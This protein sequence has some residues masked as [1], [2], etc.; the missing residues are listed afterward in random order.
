MNKI[1]FFIL[2][3]ISLVIVFEISGC[4]STI[5]TKSDQ[6]KSET[7]SLESEAD[8]WV[9]SRDLPGKTY[10]L[11][12]RCHAYYGCPSSLF[13]SKNGNIY[14]RINPDNGITTGGIVQEGTWK[15]DGKTICFTITSGGPSTNLNGCGYLMNNQEVKS[16]EERQ[17]EER[18]GWIRVE[19]GRGR[20]AWEQTYIVLK[21]IGNGDLYSLSAGKAPEA[22][23]E[24]TNQTFM[25]VTITAQSPIRPK[26]SLP[27]NRDR[28]HFSK[29]FGQ[30]YHEYVKAYALEHTSPREFETPE[31][32]EQ[33]KDDS[34]RQASEIY[35]SS[36][37]R[38]FGEWDLE[39]PWDYLGLPQ[40]D[41]YKKE[42]S[43]IDTGFSYEDI[44]NGLMDVTG[45]RSV[46]IRPP[47]EGIKDVIPING[48]PHR[49]DIKYPHRRGIVVTFKDV[50]VTPD[51]AKKWKSNHPNHL[52][53][54]NLKR[55][56]LIE[57]GG[58]PLS[59]GSHLMFIIEPV[60][61]YIKH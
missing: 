26:K 61:V 49:V 33:R 34:A 36:V 40:Y 50:K 58:G 24:K 45:I 7:A 9:P 32:Y 18:K 15:I 42:F 51:V 44:F 10:K 43:Y 31:E 47:S 14:H 3:F 57:V 52:L 37:P 46:G 38:F 20:P 13:I 56:E 8:A 41:M 55:V 19:F 4:K 2:S 28:T 53:R 5:V 17:P 54:V 25:N 59:N 29:M 60:E 30:I 35:F 11:S 39:L 12:I 48:I 27:A 21:E 16:Y 1:G 23:T 6:I 22:K